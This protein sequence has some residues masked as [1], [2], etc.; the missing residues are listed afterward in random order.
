LGRVHTLAA[1]IIHAAGRFEKT[2]RLVNY[3]AL[4]NSGFNNFLQF[5]KI[6]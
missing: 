4:K 5:S 1:V 2:P 6:K 3:F